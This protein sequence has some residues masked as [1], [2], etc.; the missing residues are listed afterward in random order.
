MDLVWSTSFDLDDELFKILHF[1][2]H[3]GIRYEAPEW[4]TL[5]STEN[6][7]KIS[8]GKERCEEKRISVPTQQLSSTQAG[9]QGRVTQ[10]QAEEK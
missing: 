6:S 5:A 4:D 1:L 3:D 7:A 9:T 10:L 2:P 8:S